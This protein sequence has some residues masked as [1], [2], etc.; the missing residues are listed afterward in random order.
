MMTTNYLLGSYVSQGMEVY[1]GGL[2]SAMGQNRHF[3]LL[4]YVTTQQ[5]EQG[6]I[7]YFYQ[8]SVYLVT[9][10]FLLSA[11]WYKFFVKPSQ[12]NL[13]TRYQSML[14][15]EN[16]YI[17]LLILKRRSKNVTFDIFL[18]LQNGSRPS[19]KPQKFNALNS[20]C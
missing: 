2:C 17:S 8:K 20:G 18:R 14:V 9:R 6:V 7:H 15:K 3:T 19:N 11:S 1:G 5:S 4:L 10:E 16:K 13:S 12:I